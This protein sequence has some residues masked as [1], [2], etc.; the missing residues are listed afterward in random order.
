MPDADT[1]WLIPLD[2]MRRCWPA[3]LDVRWQHDCSGRTGPRRRH[4][5]RRTPLMPR[6]SPRRSGRRALDDLLAA[7]RLWAEWL[8]SGRVRKL[9]MVA[10]KQQ[11]ER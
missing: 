4:W 11:S 9:A 10:E 3:G 1:V 5:P 2:D 7:H 8:D 6:R